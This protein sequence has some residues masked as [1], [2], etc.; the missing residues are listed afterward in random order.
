VLIVVGRPENEEVLPAF[1]V[2]DPKLASGDD[3][4]SSRRLIEILMLA[5][6]Q[7][8]RSIPPVVAMV[9]LVKNDCGSWGRTKQKP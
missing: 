4:D 5:D 7:E 9:L 1:G 2:D 6:C 3:G 8:L